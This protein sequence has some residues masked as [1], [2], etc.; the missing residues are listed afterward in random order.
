MKI[1]YLV[2]QYPQPSQSFI[3]REI[4]ALESLG[5]QVA[6]FTLRRWPGELVDQRDRDERQK[7]RAILEAG[8]GGLMLASLVTLLLRPAHFFHALA[9]ALRLGRKSERGRWR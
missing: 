2:N 1:A 4:A 9:M 8:A 6:R 7:T 3:R 5:A